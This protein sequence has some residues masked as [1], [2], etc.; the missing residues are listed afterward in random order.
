MLP[1][2]AKRNLLVGLAVGQEQCAVPST[3][4]AWASCGSFLQAG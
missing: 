3:L 1:V 2:E 4:V